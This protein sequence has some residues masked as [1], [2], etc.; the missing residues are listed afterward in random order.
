MLVTDVAEAIWLATRAPK[1]VLGQCYNLV[2]DVRPCA[3]E[4]IAI[5]AKAHGRAFRFHP[6]SPT[7]LWLA[8]LSKGLVKR[9]KTSSATGASYRDI[10][11]RGMT[12]EFD[13]DDVKHDLGWQPVADRDVFYRVA[14]PSMPGE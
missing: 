7:K 4:Y 2:G 12:A 9:L 11:S 14:L 3:R 8:E 13:N 5:L 6:Q 1:E 10:L